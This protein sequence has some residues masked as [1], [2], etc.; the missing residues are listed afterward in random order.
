MLF[1]KILSEN[2]DEEWKN[3]YINYN[4]LK[5][6]I[7]DIINNRP[8]AEKNFVKKLEKFWRIHDIFVNQE[9]K[10]LTDSD[11]TKELLA[12][13]IRIN[14]FINLNKE[15]FRKIIKK[16]DKNSEYKLY[17]AWKWKLIY[18]PLSNLYQKIKDVSKLYPHNDENIVIDVGTTEFKRKSIK[19]W[20]EKKNI[21]LVILH[22]IEHLPINI[23][24]EDI[25]DHIYQY[26]N[27]V[28]FDN[29][30]LELYHKRIVKEE[31][32]NIVR[33]RWYEEDN[34]NLYV[35][36]KTH[37]EDWTQLDS[38]KERFSIESNKILSYLKN[39]LIL[40]DNLA[41]EISDLIKNNKLYPIIRTVYKRI[42]FQLKNNDSIRISLDIDLKFIRENTN[43]TEWFTDVDNIEESD[44][45]YFKYAILEIKLRDNY[46]ENPPDW[47][48]NLMNSN[49]IIQKDNFS[50]FAHSVF[51]FYN[52]K[53]SKIPYWIEND[54]FSIRNIVDA[55]IDVNNNNNNGFFNCYQKRKD[56]A[57]PVRI[58][59]KTFFA[60]ERTFIQWFN[61]AIFIGSAGLAI[62]GIG[63]E[64]VGILLVVISILVTIYA[65]TIYY[66]RDRNLRLR[67]GDG[68]SDLHGPFILSIVIIIAFIFSA[69]YNK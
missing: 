3:K 55:T 36:R 68:Y 45:S 22:I 4:Y 50:K 15:G 42:A 69:I 40:E 59:P 53:C 19:F 41:N 20:V 29:D 33:I 10:R 26:I 46:I 30:D 2:L 17:P 1:D 35:E 37:H 51:T 16:H 62:I 49:L 61:C 18:N 48:K 63:K 34:N 28:Y 25:N 32:S 38:I 14:D 52:Y 11:I 13:M 43:Y 9:I 24:D 8:N 23:Y 56:I 31:G 5:E 39:N 60:N 6:V 67:R 54:D 66:K 64:I 12:E 21:L 44:I 57:N 27:S 65:L 7:N 47:I 58:E